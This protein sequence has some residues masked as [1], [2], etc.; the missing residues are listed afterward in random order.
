ML[1]G[2]SAVENPSLSLRSAAVFSLSFCVFA[3]YFLEAYTA[4][5]KTYIAI[6]LG[7][8]V[9]AGVVF[10]GYKYRTTNHPKIDKVVNEEY[11]IVTG[12]VS[13]FFEGTS[14]IDYSFEVPTVATST[15]EMDGSLVK[16]A[17][18]TGTIATLYF[19]Y[20]GGRGY[21]PT[22][23]VNYV[24]KPRVSGLVITETEESSNPDWLRI[25]SS[26]SE[27]YI[28]PINDGEW[29]VVIEAKK[30]MNV[31]LEKI[32]ATFKASRLE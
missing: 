13:R 11:K 17:N 5:M 20:E 14:T 29:L 15:S 19:S 27:W 1:E 10:V 2:G 32:I 22:E 8:V 4:S 31:E 18:A 12:S 3:Y 28:S 30:T 16:V 7:V 21:T 24:M 9:L 6:L 26:A 25:A 23:Y